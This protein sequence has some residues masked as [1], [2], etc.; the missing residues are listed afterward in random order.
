MCA[1]MPSSVS[2]APHGATYVTLRDHSGCMASVEAAER[3]EASERLEIAERVEAAKSV[4]AAQ[5][6][7][8]A[9]RLEA[10]IG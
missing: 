3:V 4:A 9:E 7:E 5:M 6:V 2:V 1:D 8:A 10:S